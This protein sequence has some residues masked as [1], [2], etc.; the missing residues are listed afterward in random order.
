MKLGRVRLDLMPRLAEGWQ[1]QSFFPPNTIVHRVGALDMTDS[2]KNLGI[3]LL[4]E[5]ESLIDLAD[6][7]LGIDVVPEYRVI[8]ADVGWHKDG[9]FFERVIP[10]DSEQAQ[11]EESMF[12]ESYKPRRKQNLTRDR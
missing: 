4:V 6:C 2:G 8:D 5:H 3:Q 1:Y 10:A 12:K 11:T 7:G 9:P